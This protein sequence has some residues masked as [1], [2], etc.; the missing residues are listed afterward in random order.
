MKILFIIPGSGDS[1][2][3]GNCFRDSLQ[4]SA[5]RQAGHEVIVMPLYLP[6]TDRAFQ[7]DTP[8]FFPATTFYVANC[9]FRNRQMPKWME[10][11]LGSKSA[12]KFAS[13]LAGSTSAEGMESMTLSMIYGDDQAFHEQVGSMI[14]WIENHEQPDIIHFSSTL[15]IGIAKAIKQRIRIP[16][17]CSMQDEEVWIDTLK[18]KFSKI[19]WKGILENIRY[20]DKYITTS[21]FYRKTALSKIPQFQDIEVIYPGVDI[22]RYASDTYPEYPVIGFFYHINRLN[23]LEILA[24]AFVKLKRK[25]T[26][27]NLK[28]K[29][30][31]GYTSHDKKFI[32]TIRKKLS[33]YVD[34]VEIKEGYRL[35]DHARYYSEISVI[36]V[37]ITF[38]ESV[39]LYLCEAFAAGRPAVEPA[40]GSFVEIVGDAGVI[41]SPNNSDA[42]A[43]ALEKILSDSEL[44]R[45]CRQN[46]LQLSTDRYNSYILAEKLESLYKK[47]C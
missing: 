3:C 47:L 46:A 2:Y 10:R 21:D 20:V 33:L 14:D 11:M 38:E 24:D 4:A 15:L 45:A 40:T 42:L 12:L 31:G 34:D 30:G 26:I 19:A 25:N 1:F 43:D 13:S 36:C 7:A 37:P 29:I 5:L 32:R 39:G 28:L 27:P 9:F 16:V 8:L 44:Y 22:D 35:E 41:Y 17:V 18:A 6:L 23:G